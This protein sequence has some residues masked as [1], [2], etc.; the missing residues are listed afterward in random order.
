M[1]LSNFQSTKRDW[2]NAGLPMPCNDPL[3]GDASLLSPHILT[4]L[5]TYIHTLCL[6]HRNLTFTFRIEPVQG[7]EAADLGHRG[8]RGDRGRGLLPAGHPDRLE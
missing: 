8:A 4:Y 3:A 7:V 5:H 1:P 6:S 2:I